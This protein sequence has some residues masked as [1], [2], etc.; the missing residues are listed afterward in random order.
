MRAASIC[1]PI[2]PGI[3]RARLTRAPA[4]ALRRAGQ[5]AAG[6]GWVV[7]SSDLLQAGLHAL[8]PRLDPLAVGIEGLRRLSG[9][10]MQEIWAFD[11]VT[12]AG[13]E[14]L[15]M[16]RA[17]GGVA[18]PGAGIGLPEEARIMRAAAEAGVPVPAIRHVLSANDGMGAGFIMDFI[19]GETLGGRIAKNPPAGLARQCGATLARIHALGAAQVPG[20]PIVNAAA[21][22]AE[23]HAAY[24]ATAW[25]RP[26]FDAALSFLSAHC[27]APVARPVLVHGDFRNGNLVV[28]EDGVRAV[29]DWELA[30]GGDG[31]E[32]LGWLCVPSWR[33]GQRGKAVGGF[34]DVDDLIGGYEDAGGDAVDRAA[35]PWWQMFGTW[36]WGVMCAG[37]VA[38]F[39]GS[40]PSVERAVI[41]RRASETEID[42]LQMLA[43]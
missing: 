3:C 15:I 12:G 36:R 1:R 27:P 39:R 10:A 42:L 20:V 30:H 41:C 21:L 13:R 31:L 5:D 19:A 23:W 26:I 7:A 11:M 14:K 43:A 32:D 4:A 40:D 6:K 38:Q 16:R 28:G 35:L 9:G 17:P 33:F 29:L 34:G 18:P 24:R 8:A 2:S 22:L 37:M 25:P